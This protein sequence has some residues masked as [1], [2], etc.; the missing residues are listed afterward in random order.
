MVISYLLLKGGPL[1]VKSLKVVQGLEPE[2]TNQFLVYLAEC[3]TDQA[4]NSE[5]AVQ[6]VLNGEQPGDNP[7]PYRKVGR[8]RFF[9]V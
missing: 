1:N 4:L 5:E 3:A 2:Y 6:K 8:L 7:P 9:N